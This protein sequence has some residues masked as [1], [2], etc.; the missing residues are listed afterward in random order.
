MTFTL[1]NVSQHDI[2]IWR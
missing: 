2:I 1:R